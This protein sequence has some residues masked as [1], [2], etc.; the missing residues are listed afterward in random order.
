MGSVLARS[1]SHK[2]Q[3]RPFDSDPRNMNTH[4]SDQIRKGYRVYD[5][6]E[7][8]GDYPRQSEVEELIEKLGPG[9]LGEVDENG[10]LY[11]KNDSK[12][13]SISGLRMER[14]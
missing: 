9:K 13:T 3:V 4:I 2:P 6:R 7:I 5:L 1:R 11:V 8:L 12:W 10:Y 14:E